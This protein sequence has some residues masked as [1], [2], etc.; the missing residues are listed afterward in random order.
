MAGQWPARH[1]RVIGGVTASQLLT[2]RLAL[3]AGAGVSALW[4]M[5]S[6]PY[7]RAIVLPAGATVGTLFPEVLPRWRDRFTG[8]VGLSWAVGGGFALHV[9]QGAYIDTWEVAALIPEAML[10]RTFGDRG[11]GLVRY[12]FYAQTSAWFHS[13]HYHTLDTPYLS[14]DPRLGPVRDH[15]AGAE[16]RLRLVGTLVVGIGY[17]VSVLHYEST[18]ALIGQVG[19]LTLAGGSWEP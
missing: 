15:T 3:R 10:A 14:G 8:F 4:G 17:D 16:L 19:M 13:N 9:Q 18:S 12:R 6:N 1:Q 7:R 2:P 11:I 5:L